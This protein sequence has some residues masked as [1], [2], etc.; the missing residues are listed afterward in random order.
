VTTQ[1]NAGTIHTDPTKRP[2]WRFFRGVPR[3]LIPDNFPAA[4]AGPD[5]LA[6]RPTRGFLL[7]PARVRRP[8]DKPHVERGVPRRPRPLRPRVAPRLKTG[9]RGSDV[10]CAQRDSKAYLRAL[11]TGRMRLGTDLPSRLQPRNR[12]QVVTVTW[13]AGHRLT[14]LG[15]VPEVSSSGASAISSRCGSRYG[16]STGR[17]RSCP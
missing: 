6:P 17:S 4:V 1:T 12:L 16:S 9:W 2:A 7:D 13:S 15:G 14:R 3:R 5:P 11:A 8:Q 10:W